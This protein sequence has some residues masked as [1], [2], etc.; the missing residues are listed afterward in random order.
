[1]ER[2]AVWLATAGGIGR[3]PWAPGT[4]GSL[5]GLVIGILAVQACG[6]GALV[7]LLA[8]FPVCTWACGEA[9]HILERHDPPAIVLDEVW[10][11]AAVIMIGVPLLR[12]FGT[13][14]PID[15]VL[16][17]L[18]DI[19]KPWPLKRLARLPGGWGIMAD[20]AGAAAYA[21]LSLVALQLL[22]LRPR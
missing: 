2:V 22:S 6:H 15:L 11:M 14:T 1:M 8:A 4:W 17:R 19:V 20:D 16:F 7:G 21:F 5:V 18:F 9:E 3:I 10:G 13:L 12:P